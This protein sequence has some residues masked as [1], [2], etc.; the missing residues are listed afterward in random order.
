M[1]SHGSVQ[2]KL[3]E[4][5]KPENRKKRRFFFRR[6]SLFFLS[7]FLHERPFD[8][9][10][11]SHVSGLISILMV[12]VLFSFGVTLEASGVQSDRSL[13]EKHFVIVSHLYLLLVFLVSSWI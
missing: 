3:A 1:C 11:W 13:I 2:A 9:N 10:E 6:R 12:F 4:D 7:C 8:T 5:E